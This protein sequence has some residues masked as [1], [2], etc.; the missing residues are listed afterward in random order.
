MKSVRYG[1]ECKGNKNTFLMHKIF[2]CTK[3]WKSI[4]IMFSDLS[5]QSWP[6]GI[7]GTNKK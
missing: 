2:F 1:L 6:I 7:E 5:E 4:E 3:T